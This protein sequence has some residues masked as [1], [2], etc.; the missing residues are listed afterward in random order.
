MKIFFFFLAALLLSVSFALPTSRTLD[1]DLKEFVD[2]VSKEKMTE[3]LSNHVASDEEFNAAIE[4]FKGSEWA[5]L[6]QDVVAKREVQD[7]KQ[8]LANSGVDVDKIIYYV[9]EWIN[10][11][12]VKDS[13]ATARGL[14]EFIE[15][16]I[17]ALPV[18]NIVVLF[19]DKLMYSDDFR[20]FYAAISNEDAHA[21][22]ETAR[23]L[24][25]VQV[26]AARLLE[27]GVDLM[28]ALELIYDLFGWR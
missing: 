25:E 3:I 5:A 28:R 15:E 13:S 7:V 4:Y 14:K 24:P 21:L 17:A 20:K 10:S 6:L 11:V 27:L 16:V 8:Y 26:L 1:D 2:L 12:E 9:W 19:Y 18:H 22:V 23:V